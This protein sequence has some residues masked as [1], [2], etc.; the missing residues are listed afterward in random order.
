M[1]IA[2]LIDDGSTDNCDVT[3]LAINRANFSCADLFGNASSPGGSVEVISTDGYSILIELI[4]TAVIVLPASL[5]CDNNSGYEYSVEIEYTISYSGTVPSDPLNTLQGFLD[6]EPESSFFTIL[7]DDEF[8][9]DGTTI[10]GTALT[11]NAGTN[12]SDCDTITPELLECTSITIQINADGIPNQFLVVPVSYG[13]SENSQQIILT[14]SDQSGNTSTCVSN[15]T[16]L[17]TIDPQAFCQDVTVNLNPDGLDTLAAASV[18]NASTDNCDI[19]TLVLNDSIFD[20][21]DVAAMQMVILTVYRY[22]WK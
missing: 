2:T 5:P 7:A 9:N 13:A 16:V 14:V 3:S 19:E 8:S 20:C 15:Y 10:T 4:P 17:D 12:R 18:N 11:A 1:K 21:S 6:C 22:K